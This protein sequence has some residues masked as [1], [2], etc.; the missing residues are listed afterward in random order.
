M[1]WIPVLIFIALGLFALV[2]SEIRERRRSRSKKTIGTETPHRTKSTEECCGQH[3]VCERDTLLNSRIEIVY[4]D[5]EELDILAGI[6][7][8]EYTEEQIQALRDVFYTLREQ[9]VAGWLRSLQ[10]RNILLP[11]ELREEALLIVSE[12]RNR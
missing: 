8:D 10:V 12:R 6:S 1:W 4:Y 11:I 2:A 5:D 9:D 3:A 7:P